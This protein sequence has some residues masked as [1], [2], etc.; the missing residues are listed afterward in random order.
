M[1]WAVSM[2]GVWGGLSLPLII[3]QRFEFLGLLVSKG[4]RVV[5]LCFGVNGSRNS[6][7]TVH[8]QLPVHCPLLCGNTFGNRTDYLGIVCIFGYLSLCQETF[9]YWVLFGYQL[10]DS[11][12]PVVLWT[13]GKLPQGV[14]SALGPPQLTAL[15]WRN[16]DDNSTP[17]FTVWSGHVKSY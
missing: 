6:K 11:R 17:R 8:W 10:C 16:V 13:S 9:T 7:R 2:K 12:E 3:F 5:T 1:L 14:F 15:V 4:T